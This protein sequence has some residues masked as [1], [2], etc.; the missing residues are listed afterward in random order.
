MSN[1]FINN[2][3]ANNISANNISAN[4]VHSGISPN[5]IFASSDINSSDDISGKL[6]YTNIMEIIPENY[7]IN[8]IND[9]FTKYDTEWRWRFLKFNGRF[10]VELSYKNINNKNRRFCDKYGEWVDNVNIDHNYD[11]YVVEEYYV[12]T[13]I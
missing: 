2:I 6:T 5:N 11:K 4:N 8:P 12:Y 13:K 1:I 3:P 7:V 9:W 10:V